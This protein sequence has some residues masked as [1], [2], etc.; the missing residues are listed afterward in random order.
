MDEQMAMPKKERSRVPKEE[1]TRR[2][3]RRQMK[4]EEA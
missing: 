2:H 1:K 3:T 4:L